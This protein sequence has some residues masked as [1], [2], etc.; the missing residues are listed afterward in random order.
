MTPIV[1]QWEVP[2]IHIGEPTGKRIEEEGF[3]KI[4][5]L[6]TKSTMEQEYLRSYYRGFGIEISAP[7]EEQRIEIDRIIFEELVRGNIQKSSK[8]YF[9]KVLQKMQDGE[10]IEGMIMG[11]TE[12]FLLVQQEDLPLVKMYDTTKLHCEALVR[13]SLSL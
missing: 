13:H 12:I 9:I 6:G 2:F 10:G 11:C 3:K 7:N 1:S 5:L 8:E 4:A